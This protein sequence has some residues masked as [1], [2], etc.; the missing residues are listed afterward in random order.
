MIIFTIFGLWLALLLVCGGL[1]LF[2]AWVYSYRKIDKDGL[3]FGLLAMIIWATLMVSFT[4]VT[5][6]D[7]PE[8]HGYERVV[9][10]EN[11]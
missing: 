10:N 6:I 2:F 8:S 4:V 11:N 5:F 3:L 7:N 1:S 9:K